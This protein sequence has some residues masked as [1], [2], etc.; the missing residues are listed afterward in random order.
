MRCPRDDLAGATNVEYRPGGLGAVSNGRAR[1]ISDHDGYDDASASL[2]TGTLSSA[3]PSGDIFSDLTVYLPI[4][5]PARTSAGSETYGALAPIAAHNLGDFGVNKDLGPVA[6]PDTA[7]RSPYAERETGRSIEPLSVTGIRLEV[8]ESLNYKEVTAARP[9][10]VS[11]DRLVWDDP[12]V[13]SAGVRYVLHDPLAANTQLIQT[14]MAGIT[15]SA[16]LTFLW[17]MLEPVVQRKAGLS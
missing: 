7:T 5:T 12:E 14:F 2:L 9:P 4:S 10:V 8:R 13:Q 11:D 17:L 16:A 6:H 1:A 15:G 3:S